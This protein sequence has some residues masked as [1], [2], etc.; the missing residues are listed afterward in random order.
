M[1]KLGR[2]SVSGASVYVVCIFLK[3]KISLKVYSLKNIKIILMLIHSIKKK[4]RTLSTAK[5]KRERMRIVLKTH[6]QDTVTAFM[7]LYHVWNNRYGNTIKLMIIKVSGKS[8][9]YALC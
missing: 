2:H 4:K 8:I 5:Q 6:T 9:I 1:K 3:R 7:F